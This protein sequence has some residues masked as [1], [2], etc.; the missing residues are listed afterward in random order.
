M[1]DDTV[2]ADHYTILLKSG[3]YYVD[4][5]TRDRV[6]EARQSG[7]TRVTFDLDN[8]CDGCD[9]RRTVTI[10]PAD[11]LAFIAHD[12]LGTVAENVIPFPGVR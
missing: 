6:L 9:H 4:S 2:V 12:D 7:G 8:P 10:S 11:V 5:R 3:S 1:I